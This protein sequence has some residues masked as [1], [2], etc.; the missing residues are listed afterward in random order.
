MVWRLRKD[1]SRDVQDLVKDVVVEGEEKE[2]E[3]GKDE[4][5]TVDVS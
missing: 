1:K 2:D 4:Y 3:E 5:K